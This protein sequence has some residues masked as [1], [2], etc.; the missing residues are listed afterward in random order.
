M[1]GPPAV[2][3]LKSLYLRNYPSELHGVLTVGWTHSIKNDCNQID[4]I[5]GV[6]LAGSACRVKDIKTAR[7]A[8]TQEWLGWFSYVCMSVC[9]RG[10]EFLIQCFVS[11]SIEVV[12]NVVFKTCKVLPS[13]MCQYH[14]TCIKLC[15]PY[16]TGGMLSDIWHPRHF[17][18]SFFGILSQL[19]WFE[20]LWSPYMD[21][22]STV[23][24]VI[25]TWFFAEKMTPAEKVSGLRPLSLLT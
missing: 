8:I 24:V 19:P 7:E 3:L 21:L 5:W 15:P 20:I 18:F 14:C 16:V 2:P 13:G 6:G 4:L 22:T 12:N 23:F 25:R 17:H 11:H 10:R 1:S 9:M